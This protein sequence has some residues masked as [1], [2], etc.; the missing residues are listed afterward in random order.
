MKAQLK[1]VT[2][3][4]NNSFKVKVLVGKNVPHSWKT[5]DAKNQQVKCVVI[6]WDKESFEHWIVKPKF[7][8]IKKM[9]IET[10][11]SVSEI[12][13]KSGFNNLSFFHRQ[14]NKYKQIS[15]NTYGQTYQR[16]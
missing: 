11:L 14:F 13:Y 5:I 15:P 4:P 7:A 9:L 2:I 16:I 3:P 1:Q 12:G 6:Q 8:S 10:D